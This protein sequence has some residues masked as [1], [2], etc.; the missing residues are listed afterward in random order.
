MTVFLLSPEQEKTDWLP[1]TDIYRAPWGWLL[2]FD[3]AGVRLGDVDVRVNRNTVA[4]S[5]IRRDYTVEEGCCHYSMEITYSRFQRTIELPDNLSGS[6]FRMDY[7]DGI[8]FVRI[9][10]EKGESK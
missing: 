10:R 1:A 6:Q 4:V 3:I 2:K 8:L 5:G 7:R 9:K